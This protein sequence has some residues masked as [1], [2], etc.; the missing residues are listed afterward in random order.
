M[1]CQTYLPNV[2]VSDKAEVYKLQKTRGIS[3]RK[4]GI[5]SRRPQ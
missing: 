1:S 2:I 4:T 3:L 5:L